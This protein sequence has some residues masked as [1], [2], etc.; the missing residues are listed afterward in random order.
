MYS[1]PP[2][3]E[4]PFPL[5]LSGKKHPNAGNNISKQQTSIKTH[6][7]GR[8]AMNASNNT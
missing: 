5:T 8:S 1:R 7:A 6:L 2:L 4:E 3:L